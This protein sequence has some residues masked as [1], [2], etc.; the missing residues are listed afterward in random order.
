MAGS[1]SITT[2][3][4][5]MKTGGLRPAGPPIAVARGGPMAPLRSGGRAL[6]ARNKPTRSPN[7]GCNGVRRFLLRNHELVA[8]AVHG[9]QPARR[10]DV[11]FELRAQL[12]DVDVD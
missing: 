10:R 9:D 7:A 8:H 3:R 12:R 11:V 6:G 1:S 2:M 5:I 4:F